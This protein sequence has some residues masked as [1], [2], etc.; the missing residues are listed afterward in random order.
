MRLLIVLT[1]LL[2]PLGCDKQIHEARA[3]IVWTR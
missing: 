1:F 3:P 2:A